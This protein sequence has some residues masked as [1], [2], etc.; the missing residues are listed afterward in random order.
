MDQKVS[1]ETKRELL[2]ALKNRYRVSSK[3]EKG[4]IL[5]EFT[6]VSGYHRKHAIRLLRT[7]DSCMEVLE[8][9]PPTHL[10]L[11]RR[12]YDEAV[13][14]ALIVIWEAGE[15]ICGKRLKAI[16]PDLVASLARISHHRSS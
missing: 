12:V 5:D 7:K 14:E 1:K 9:G 6:S 11:G 10:H 13:K 16:L 15:R 3:K 8:E 2:E 4:R